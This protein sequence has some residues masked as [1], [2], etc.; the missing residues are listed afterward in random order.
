MPFGSPI[1]GMHMRLRTKFN[2]ILA[3][4]FAVGLAVSAALSSWLVQR[5][6]VE[7]VLQNARIMRASAK[8]I[9]SYTSSEIQPLLTGMM[10]ERFLPQSVPSYSAQEN[11]RKL[12]ASFPHFTYKEAA[13]NPT[14]PSDRATD[15]ESDII[16]MFRNNPA[17]PEIV[18]V[19]ETPAGKVLSLAEPIQIRDQNCLAC[20]STPA[21]APAPLLAAYGS[22]NGFGWQLNEIV[23]AQIVSVPMAVPFARAQQTFLATMGMTLGVF[24]LLFIVLNLLLNRIVIRPIRRISTL[25]D[26]VSLGNLDAPEHEA[27]G[28]D[29]IA[30]LSTAF[31]RMRRSLVNALRLLDH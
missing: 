20:H 8:A 25:A 10:Q 18:T 6:G 14:N 16:Q 30:T 7:E 17:L 26:E 9:R 24:I 19:R 12:Q 29:E 1:A 15:W 31:N 27:R 5:N 13:L 2:L 21:N 3:L 23:G 28:K 4:T 22:A 11:F